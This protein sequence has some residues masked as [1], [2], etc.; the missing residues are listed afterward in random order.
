MWYILFMANLVPYNPFP[1][2]LVGGIYNLAE[3]LLGQVQQPTIFIIVNT[4]IKVLPIVSL[5][6]VPVRQT[7]IQAGFVYLFV[8]I[9]WLFINKEDLMKIRTPLSDFIS[10]KGYTKL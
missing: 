8:Y 10:E 1:F 4:F 2:L 9:L 3:L 7:D 5:I 6:G